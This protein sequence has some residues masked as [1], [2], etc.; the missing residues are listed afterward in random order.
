MYILRQAQELQT[1]KGDIQE[2]L[3]RSKS[4]GTPDWTE[5]GEWEAPAAPQGRFEGETR[6]GQRELKL[7]NPIRIQSGARETV[8]QKRKRGSDPKLTHVGSKLQNLRGCGGRS[9]VG[10]KLKNACRRGFRLVLFFRGEGLQHTS[11]RLVKQG[12]TQA[13]G[14][15][16]RRHFLVLSLFLPSSC[17]AR[18][19]GVYLREAGTGE[20][21]FC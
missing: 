17:E 18:W 9:F 2:S 19:G 6:S 5:M 12:A 10:M 16:S 8:L 14:K 13:C 7:E 1:R 4:P 3:I 21:C 11:T 15:R 20:R